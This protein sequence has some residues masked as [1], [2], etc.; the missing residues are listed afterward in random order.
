LYKYATGWLKW[1][2]QQAL[3][4]PI[5]HILIAMDGLKDCFGATIAGFEVNSHSQQEINEAKKAQQASLWVKKHNAVI[6]AK[7]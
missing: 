2:R 4:A 3:N 5:A 1:D 6:K 7:K